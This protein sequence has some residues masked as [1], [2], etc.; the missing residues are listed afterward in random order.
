MKR[1]LVHKLRKKLSFNPVR[2]DVVPLEKCWEVTYVVDCQPDT[3]PPVFTNHS[4][5]WKLVT[6]P[7]CLARRPKLRDLS[8]PPA[9]AGSSTHEKSS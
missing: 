3:S 8:S 9:S 5:D 6:C 4:L 7:R 1:G 2:G